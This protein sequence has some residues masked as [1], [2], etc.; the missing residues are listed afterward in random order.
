MAIEQPIYYK[1]LPEPIGDRQ[2]DFIVED[3]ILKES[4]S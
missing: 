3:K 4:P 1:D 2:A